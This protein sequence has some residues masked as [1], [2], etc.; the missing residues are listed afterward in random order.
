MANTQSGIDSYKISE[1]V[2][3]KESLRQI[4]LA[5]KIVVNKTRRQH[6]KMF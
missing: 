6:N 4:T 5:H 3:E 1:D 2:Q